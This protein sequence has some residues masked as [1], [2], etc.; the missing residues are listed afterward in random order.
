MRRGTILIA[1]AIIV[2]AP[3]RAPTTAYACSCV[4][5]TMQQLVE[6]ADA[7]FVGLATAT[8]RDPSGDGSV[9]FTVEEVYKGAVPRDGVVQTLSLDNTCGIEFVPGTVYTVFTTAEAGRLHEA[10]CGGSTAD[11]GILRRAGLVPTA[12]YAA[13]QPSASAKTTLDP[14]ELATIE[15]PGRTGIIGAAALLLVGAVLASFLM[16]GTIGLRRRRAV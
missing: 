6:G 1:A 10:A 16:R 11:G 14:A 2:G 5:Q 4:Q 8:E 7:V 15:N 13:P 3:V 12:T 9:R